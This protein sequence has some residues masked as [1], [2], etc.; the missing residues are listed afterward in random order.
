VFALDKGAYLLET[1]LICVRDVFKYT[2]RPINE[3]NSS[4]S[5]ALKQNMK[6][7]EIYPLEK[8]KVGVFAVGK[9]AVPYLSIAV[10]YISILVYRGQSARSTPS[11]P[12]A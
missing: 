12:P 10:A 5:A 2:S 6:T 11:P 8:G 3:I 9:G 1:S 4:A 7:N